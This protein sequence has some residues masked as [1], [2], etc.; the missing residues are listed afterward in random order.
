MEKKAC[1]AR[2]LLILKGRNGAV[3]KSRKKNLAMGLKNV[4]H[5]RQGNLPLQEIIVTCGTFVI[6]WQSVKTSPVLLQQTQIPF[7]WMLSGFCRFSFLSRLT[8]LWENVMKFWSRVDLREN[9][10][11][12]IA[13]CSIWYHSRQKKKKKKK[14]NRA[15]CHSVQMSYTVLYECTVQTVISVGQ[16]GLLSIKI[17]PFGAC[18][19]SIWLGQ[20][21]RPNEWREGIHAMKQSISRPSSGNADRE[22]ALDGLSW[23]NVQETLRQERPRLVQ[24]AVP[25]RLPYLLLLLRLS[26][27][28]VPTG[29]QISLLR[30]PAKPGKGSRGGQRQPVLMSYLCR[31]VTFPILAEEALAGLWGEIMSNSE[32]ATVVKLAAAEH[33]LTAAPSA[34][35]CRNICRKK[36]D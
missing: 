17:G 1:S 12:V 8:A 11:C 31:P 28:I 2:F 33:E 13:F 22:K 26:S 15:Q 16:K 30:C 23:R 35:V 5:G 29:I 18:Q 10:L 27:L 36:K 14:S 6:E 25:L 34:G 9:S 4:F 24:T 3:F 19:H 20:C 7:H 21:E 32:S